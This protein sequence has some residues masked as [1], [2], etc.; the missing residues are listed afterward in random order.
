MTKSNITVSTP[1]YQQKL[2]DLLDVILGIEDTATQIGTMAVMTAHAT[3]RAQKRGVSLENAVLA[4]R[5]GK[6][7][8]V[9]AGLFQRIIRKPEMA[10]LCKKKLVSPSALDKLKDLAVITDESRAVTT[11]ITVLGRQG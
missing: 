11:V 10:D 5:Y 2:S 9:K 4:A 7:L 1:I 8:R 6:R 3:E